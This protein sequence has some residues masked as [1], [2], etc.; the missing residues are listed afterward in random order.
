M[1]NIIKIIIVI[2]SVHQ[3]IFIKE[4]F[5]LVNAHLDIKI[6]VMEVVLSSTVI[7]QTIQIQQ[8]VAQTI[9][10]IIVVNVLI[11]ALLENIQIQTKYA[12][13]CNSN[14]TTCQNST[15]CITC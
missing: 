12:R 8:L 4:D 13:D 14:C 10:T 3:I 5:V 9:S 11:N 2:D 1:V 7:L 6:T 15:I